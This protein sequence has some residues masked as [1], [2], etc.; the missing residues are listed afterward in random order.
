MKFLHNL[1]QQLCG[2]DFSSGLPDPLA[3]TA[4]RLMGSLSL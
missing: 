2:L 1:L 4:C 3:Q